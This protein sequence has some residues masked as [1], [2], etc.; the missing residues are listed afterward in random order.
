[1]GL[2][3]VAGDWMDHKNFWRNGV[4]ELVSLDHAVYFL[5]QVPP[6]PIGWSFTSKQRYGSTLGG[7]VRRLFFIYRPHRGSQH[8]VT[9][10]CK[11]TFPACRKPSCIITRWEVATCLQTYRASKMFLCHCKGFVLLDCWPISPSVQ[12]GKRQTGPPSVSTASPP[13]SAAASNPQLCTFKASKNDNSCGLG[14]LGFLFQVMVDCLVKP[15]CEGAMKGIGIRFE[16]FT[17]FGFCASV[18]LWLFLEAASLPLAVSLAAESTT[19]LEEG[20]MNDVDIDSRV[21]ED[22]TADIG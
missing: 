22:T 9:V 11:M 13:F 18:L 3:E 14:P 2:K 5:T 21:V 16:Q 6:L 1:M 8:T 19:H 17:S 4:L 20:W 7:S 12:Y 15:N 10:R